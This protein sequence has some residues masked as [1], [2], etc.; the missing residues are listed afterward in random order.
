MWKLNYVKFKNK[1]KLKKKK[2]AKNKKINNML[3]NNQGSKQSKEKSKI[4]LRHLK[5]KNTTYQNTGCSKCSSKRQGDSSQC[6]P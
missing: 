2:K 5:M 3:E 1:I 4:T 6:L